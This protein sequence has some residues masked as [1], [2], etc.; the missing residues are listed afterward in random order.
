MI[1]LNLSM[2]REGGES[3]STPDAITPAIPRPTIEPSEGISPE[4]AVALAR[5]SSGNHKFA[6]KLIEFRIIGLATKKMS[7]PRATSQ[8]FSFKKLN[9]RIQP[10]INWRAVAK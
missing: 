3:P 2:Q 8:N 5:S 1:T 9:T 10:P 7:I 4:M 6:I